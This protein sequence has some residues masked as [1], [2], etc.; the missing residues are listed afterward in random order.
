MC[1]FITMT[2]QQK[3]H[4]GLGAAHAIAVSIA[5]Q[6][7]GPALADDAA[8]PPDSAKF[9]FFPDH[10]SEL[11]MRAM[12]LVGI[13]YKHGGNSPENGLDCSGLVQFVVREA[14]GTSLPR[15]SEEISRTGKSID[16]HELQP[17]DLVFY[18]TLNRP[19]SHVGIYLGD[20][21]FL[22][23]PSAGGKVRIERM[24]VR[25]WQKRYDGARRISDPK[26]SAML[27]SSPLEP[28]ITPIANR[29][30]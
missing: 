18:N 29:D 23:S 4:R 11:A 22:H 24:D 2:I 15:T 27:D 25:Y 12:A 21:K 19:F 20:N 16:A 28:Q 6:F 17:G 3:N 8:L 5:L 1:I 9:Q 13:Q 14:W 26:R 30:W 10:G 7:C